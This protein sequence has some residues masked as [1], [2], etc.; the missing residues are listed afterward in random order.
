MKAADIEQYVG[1]K[2]RVVSLSDLLARADGPGRATWKDLPHSPGIY[3]VCLPSWRAHS[4]AADAGRAKHAKPENPDLLR[5][6]LDRILAAGPTDIL[7]IGKAIQLRQRVCQLARFGLGRDSNHRGGE[8]LWQL[9]GINKAH[10]RMWR[11]LR[12]RPEP[13]ERELLDRFRH[14][15]GDLPLANRT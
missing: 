14:D 1:G 3:A 10:V 13:L 11:Y 8:W 6:K 5:N 4:F 2:A 15:H 7:Y 12:A 9:E